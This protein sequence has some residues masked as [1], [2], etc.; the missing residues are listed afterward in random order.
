MIKQICETCKWWIPDDASLWYPE[1]PRFGRCLESEYSRNFK[2][3]IAA[4]FY[5]ELLYWIF[6]KWLRTK[7]TF[8][9]NQWK[10]DVDK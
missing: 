9:C 10:Q 8:G 4:P 7:F 5:Y 6:D 3:E 1:K 2:Y